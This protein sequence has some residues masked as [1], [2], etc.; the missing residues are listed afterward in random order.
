M[1]IG[2]NTRIEDLQHVSMENTYFIIKSALQIMNELQVTLIIIHFVT[3]FSFAA[4]SI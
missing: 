4:Q 2:V 1:A 3:L